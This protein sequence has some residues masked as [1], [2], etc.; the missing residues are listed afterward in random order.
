MH[1]HEGSLYW[2]TTVTKRFKVLPVEKSDCYDAIIVGGG[3]SGTLTAYTLAKAG[4]K[5]AIIDK[6]PFGTGSTAA[7]TGLL[8][9]SNDIMLHEL[10]QQIGEAN[11][12]RFYK[13]CYQAIEQLEEIAITL[14]DRADFIRRPS[15]YYAS[16]QED[17]SRLQKEYEALSSNGFPC[18]F[19]TAKEIINHMPFQKPGAIVTQNDAEINPYKFVLGLLEKL[20]EEGVHLLEGIEVL[21]TTQDEETGIITVHTSKEELCAKKVIYTTGYEPLPF[22]K[23]QGAEINRSYAIVTK[24]M[25]SLNNWYKRALIW[26]TKRPYLYLRTTVDNRIIAG[27]LDEDS[28]EAPSTDNIVQQHADKL[29]DEL[30]KLFPDGVIEAEY[31][32]GATFGESIDNLPFIGEHPNQPNHFYLQGYG[33]NGTV[34]SMLGSNILIDLIQG[35][36]NEDARLVTL[37]RPNGVI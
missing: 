22:G 20:Q 23:R 2:P 10:A 37:D 11:A 35:H 12:I 32:Y 26:E 18:E 4:L 34:Y 31:M 9:F 1:I 27:G 6:R 19:W 3:M 21:D 13:L 29:V 8:Q 5:V 7:N 17:V 30:Q 16:S 15:I 36:E 24:P 14:Q 28:P 25:K 33:G